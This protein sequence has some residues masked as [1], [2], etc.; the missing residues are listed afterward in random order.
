MDPQNL[1]THLQ[2]T[3]PECLYT[4]SLSILLQEKQLKPASPMPPEY[5]PYCSLEDLTSPAYFLQQSDKKQ[6]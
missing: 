4:Y 2:E 3:N 1:Q 6:T 5:S